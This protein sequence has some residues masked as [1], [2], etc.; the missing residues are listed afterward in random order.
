MNNLKLNFGV[1][2]QPNVTYGRFWQTALAAAVGILAFV[3]SSPI[4]IIGLRLT[5]A[6]GIDNFRLAIA[7]VFHFSAIVE[8][9]SE[10]LPSAN[11][12]P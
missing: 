1:S 3:L 10:S 7:V 4:G 12:P 5:L 9:K 6:L 11:H 8:N 2:E